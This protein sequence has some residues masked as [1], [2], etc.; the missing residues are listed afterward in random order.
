MISNDYVKSQVIKLLPID[1]NL[2]ADQIDILIGGAMNKLKNEGINT[3]NIDEGTNVAFDYCICC[4]Y[5]VALDMDADI[6]IERMYR[7][8]ISRVNT[9]R[10]NHV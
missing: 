7:Q 9:L 6:D 1:S 4:S 8:Y 10:T 5:Q 2:Y 3:D